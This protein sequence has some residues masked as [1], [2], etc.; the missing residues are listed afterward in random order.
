MR[1]IVIPET[2]NLN[3]LGKPWTFAACVEHVVDHAPEFNRDGKGIR[4]G[5]RILE[6]VDQW[7]PG[8]AIV[9]REEDWAMLHAQME[10][11]SGGYHPKLFLVTPDGTRGDELPVPERR[12]LPYVEAVANATEGEV[13]PAAQLVPTV[14]P[15]SPSAREQV[16]E[17]LAK[18][19]EP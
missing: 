15:P 12:V 8:G 1:I 7:Q 17:A 11:P 13:K 4:A 6:G 10:A 2:A 14:P 19:E 5:A 16:L 3:I 9:L 18:G